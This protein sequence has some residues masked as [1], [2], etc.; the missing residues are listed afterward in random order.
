M[1]P[2]ARELAKQYGIWG[3]HPEFTLP[4]WQYEVRNDD[5]RLGYWDWV[6]QQITDHAVTT[7]TQEAQP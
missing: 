6:H 7:T 4:Y 5:T 1:T 3:E 2:E